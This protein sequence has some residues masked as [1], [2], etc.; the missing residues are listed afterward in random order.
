MN[1]QIIKISGNDLHNPDYI[2]QFASAVSRLPQPMII[3]HGGGKMISELQLALGL[4][5]RKVDGLRITDAATL[6]TTEM[7]MSGQVNKLL[8]RA[9][10]AAGVNAIGLSGVDG[11]ILQ[12]RK[13]PHPNTDLGFV[14]EIH[15]V[16]TI[17]LNQLLAQG[18]TILISPIS[19]GDDGSAYNVN[20][21]DAASALATACDASL[22]TF[23]SNVPGVMADGR[24]LATLTPAETE[25]L[26]TDRVITDGMIPKVRAATRLIEAGVARAKITDLQGLQSGVGTVFSRQLSVVTKS[27]K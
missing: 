21:D 17:L 9:L 10:L 12:C 23:V 6:K 5:T 25:Q 1:T 4:Q 13:R 16:N 24:L 3:V 22:L 11:A 20:A 15:T 8:V 26:I 27:E 2:K 18:I 7:A 14:G 19:L